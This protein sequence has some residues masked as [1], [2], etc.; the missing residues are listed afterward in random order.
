MARRKTIA[1]ADL[2][3]AAREVFTEG[4][5]GASTREVARRAGVSEGVLFQRFSSKR[6]LFFAAMVLP[7]PFPPAAHDIGGADGVERLFD[8]AEGMTEYFRATLP[9]LLPLV[10]HP[11]F[12]F[13]EFARRHPDSPLEQLRRRLVTFFATE[14]DAGRI[15]DVHPGAAAL[16]VL[17]LAQTTAFFERMGAHGGRFPPELLRRGLR[18]LWDGLAPPTARPSSRAAG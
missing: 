1:D 8:L 6:E 13:E 17:S 7:A 14:R 5:F 15:R 2:L 3:A 11:G 16:M 18:C 12:R 10:T 4:G 9:V